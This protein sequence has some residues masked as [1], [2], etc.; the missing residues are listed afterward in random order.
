MPR[1]HP[2]EKKAD[3]A[4]LL[5]S[6]VSYDRVSKLIGVPIATLKNWM[7]EEDFAHEMGNV[8]DYMIGALEPELI[9]L[10][11]L[12]LNNL[13]E[14]MYDTFPA[15]HPKAKLSAKILDGTLLPAIAARFATAPLA[16]QGLAGP[17][18]ARLLERVSSQPLDR[19]GRPE[20]SGADPVPTVALPGRN[21]RRPARG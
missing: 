1:E 14:V 10:L 11:H 2:P 9:L 18:G 12:C 15:E 8:R 5:G 4:L 7:D 17:E 3:A 19:V 21:S 16:N 20:T 13:I 6:A